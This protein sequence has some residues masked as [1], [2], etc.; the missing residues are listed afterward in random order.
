MRIAS[1]PASAAAAAAGQPPAAAAP[2]LPY[3]TAVDPRAAGRVGLAVALLLAMSELSRLSGAVLDGEG[4]SWPF[5]QLM[6]PSRLVDWSAAGW[7]A[8]GFPLDLVDRL[9]TWL[10]AYVLLDLVFVVLYASVLLRWLGRRPELLVLIGADVTEDGLALLAGRGDDAT[11]TA[12][13]PLVSL[14]KWAALLVLIVRVIVRL[15]HPTQGEAD[16]ARLVRLRRALYLHR[17]SLVPL[18]PVLALGLISGPNLLDQLPDVIRQ[19][20]TLDD[21]WA[22]YGWAALV[23][24][25][26][27]A[28]MLVLG[29]MRS[30]FAHARAY[31]TSEDGRPLPELRMYLVG[32]A[33]V[34]LGAALV[35][36]V[37]VDWTRA[38][39][40]CAAPVLIVGLSLA[41]RR[42]SG[43]DRPARR[44][45]DPADVP[46]ITAVGDIVAMAPLAVGGLAL[47]RSY[48]AVA[49]LDEQDALLDPFVVQALLVGVV[50]AAFGW[51]VAA[52]MIDLAGR[53]PALRAVLTVG[54]APSFGPWWR[55]GAGAVW[56]MVFVG[57]MT[58]PLHAAEVLGV[59]AAVLLSLA[60]LSLLIGAFVV[61]AQDGG[62]PE[63][64]WKAGLRS[65]PLTLL[66]VG[67]LYLASL[68]GDSVRVHGIR[69]LP[70]EA[71]AR[72][73]VSTAF[74]DWVAQ[75]DACVHRAGEVDLRPLL[76]VA[77]EG[78]GVR[79]A[80]WTAAGLDAM[81]AQVPCSTTSTL[82]SGG[83]SGGSV[84][85][86]VARFAPPGEAA[87]QVRDLAGPTA[88]AAGAVG[89]FT[90]DLAYAA[91]GVPASPRGDTA[92]DERL[93]LTGNQGWADRPALMEA[94]WEAD[95]PALRGS[96]VVAPGPAARP[97]GHLVLTS[98][99]VGTG[100]RLVV[101]QLDLGPAATTTGC[102]GL[103]QPVAGSVDLLGAYPC[104]GPLPA[105][106]AALLSGRFPFVTPS[107]VLPACGGSPM[108]QVVDGG[109]VE[110]T[111]I[112]T[113]VDL[114]ERWLPL[115][116]AHNTAELLG[117]G[118]PTL[119]VPVVVYLDNGTGSD[120]TVPS[121]QVADEL[122]VPWTAN[123]RART[124]QSSAP[125]LLQR[126]DALV[127]TPGL[128]DGALLAGTACG[129][130]RL[131]A[132]LCALA[133]AARQEID[134]W[135]EWPVVVVHQS[136]T[137]SVTAPLGWVLSEDS[138]RTMDQALREQALT[139]CR[140]VEPVGTQAPVTRAAGAW[141]DLGYGTFGDLLGMLRE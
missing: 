89:L 13:L 27:S 67:S 99:S 98:T 127:A 71:G 30:D 9:G 45:L 24:L 136:T 57:L 4:R 108:D 120:F 124:Q 79:A 23:L 52:R 75:D 80:Y 85:L 34:L 11:W 28:G 112:G 50:G 119:V 40:F 61:I 102:A 77:A 81:V 139:R 88:L 36:G 59:I 33:V 104:L 70:G 46:T 116:R 66:L 113:V 38:A 82:L 48:T 58:Y 25:L 22:Q 132:E 19:W 65:P 56:L 10:V 43:W 31:A 1:A 93:A 84:G 54:A 138:M 131:A 111:G 41:A 121:V 12:V 2:A 92:V 114:S 129:E 122:L 141:C 29:R 35:R 137:P 51:W 128:V 55:W 39:V 32:P 103:G 37:G 68:A 107:G 16:R 94:V 133:D 115:V 140:A 62:A 91:T 60:A 44:G 118:R 106:T 130:Q 95:V 97:S 64:F 101:S 3:A 105:S 47:V 125:T 8:T 76:L 96:F 53:V 109:Y 100:C 72:D 20:R 21:G 78:G 123:G 74:A 49:A 26:L 17:F 117:A 5:E 87:D 15:L 63:V 18:L 83:A 14:V 73:T 110:N 42:W 69:T 90:R 135:R 7:Q 6:G 86:A 134:R 126:A